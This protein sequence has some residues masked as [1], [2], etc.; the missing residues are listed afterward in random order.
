MFALTNVLVDWRR[1]TALVLNSRTPAGTMAASR[2]PVRSSCIQVQLTGTPTGTVTVAGLVGGVAD[3]EVL[4]WAGVAGARV[5]VKEFTTV[6][7]TSSLTGAVKVEASAV[8]MDGT[9]QAGT[10][11]IKSSWPVQLGAAGSGQRWP[12]QVPGHEPTSD[13]VCRVPYE[14]TWAPREG[15][16]VD[17]VQPATG[18]VFQVFGRPTVQVVGMAQDHW[19]VKLTQQQGA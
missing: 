5:T 19:Q 15:D 10:Y 13:R 9:P 3:S 18:E 6:A 16:V 7:F 11:A 8:G 2:A 12:G 4:T 17:V 1:S 14:E